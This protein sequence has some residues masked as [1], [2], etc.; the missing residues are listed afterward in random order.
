[1]TIYEMLRAN[2]CLLRYFASNRVPEPEP[3]QPPQARFDF[4]LLSFQELEALKAISDKLT[5]GNTDAP[6]D[7]KEDRSLSGA[8]EGH[9]SS[10]RECNLPT[11]SA[12][13]LAGSGRPT[14]DHDRLTHE[15]SQSP[16]RV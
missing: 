3:R 14:N 15:E 6:R 11:F 10:A 9:E 1:V 13:L 16:D 4:G 2:E 7:P 12:L 8:I 5:S